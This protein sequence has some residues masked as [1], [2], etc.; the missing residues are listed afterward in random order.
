[1]SLEKRKILK[2][3]KKLIKPLCN[4]CIFMWQARVDESD[5]L[6]KTFSILNIVVYK[7]VMS[8]TY[9]KDY[10]GRR[11]VRILELNKTYDKAMIKK[12]E[13]KV[14]KHDLELKAYS[15][16]FIFS[17][18]SG[19][20]YLFLTYVLKPFIEKTNS[21]NLL[22]ILTKNY[23][24]DILNL[25][26]IKVP[27]ILVE[28]IGLFYGKIK[29][30]D[31]QR[32]FTI[33]TSS[34]FMKVEDL[35]RNSKLDNAHYFDL[36]LKHLDISKDS[37]DYK[38]VNLNTAFSKKAKNAMLEK[39]QS[40]NLNLENFVILAPEAASCKSIKASF[41]KELTKA[42]EAK[43]IDIFIN[44]VHKNSDIKLTRYKHCYLS[45]SEVYMLA[46]LSLGVVGLRSGLLENLLQA[47]VPIFALYTSFKNRS[48]FNALDSKHVFAGFNLSYL[49]SVN[50]SLL[51]EMDIENKDVSEV[52]KIIVSETSLKAGGDNN[53][54]NKNAKMALYDS[55][56]I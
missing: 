53:T 16:I 20:I 48:L 55:Y 31:K 2:N 39:I 17:S 28:D 45:L 14:K 19:E 46:R 32:F 42:L 15:D 3:I 27:Y 38:K 26:D 7:R 9:I 4:N 29:T 50:K 33:F 11:L 30:I 5:V 13:D 43:G 52:V 40:I 44:A 25:L 24:I 47:D 22:F 35:I 10:Q 6:T 12:Y 8:E 49:P 34:Y 41:W 56:R 21:K 54:S 51:F 1:M 36:M 18:N 23:H 37:L